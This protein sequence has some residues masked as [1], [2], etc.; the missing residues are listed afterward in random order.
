MTSLLLVYL[1]YE[2]GDPPFAWRAGEQRRD[3]RKVHEV[4]SAFGRRKAQA[5]RQ[6]GHAVRF[7]DGLMLETS[8][9]LR[10]V[11]GVR[12]GAVVV[13]RDF[14]EDDSWA[15]EMAGQIAAVLRRA[16]AECDPAALGDALRWG[17][18]A[19]DRRLFPSIGRRTSAGRVRLGAGG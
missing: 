13:V 2:N 15:D 14:P 5:H 7:R 3:H 11:S 4:L 1:E 19:T 18:A 17:R 12:Q 8:W 16:S 9:R 6:F 10:H